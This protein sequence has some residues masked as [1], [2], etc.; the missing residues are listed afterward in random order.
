MGRA[1][2]DGVRMGPLV[3]RA[4]Q[5]RVRD[6]IVRGIA[7]GAELVTGGSEAP[8]GLEGGFFVE[9][10]VFVVDDPKSP[11][12]QEEIFGP[13]AT[14]VPY[15]TVDD[16]VR[17]ANDTP[18]GLGG[19]VRAASDDEAMAVARRIRTGQITINGG[20]FN[21]LAPFGGFKQSATAAK[22]GDSDCRSSSSTSRCSCAKRLDRWPVPPNWQQC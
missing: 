22:A 14:L 1:Q 21:P 11:L 16:A 13:V 3:S 10:T 2:D 20:A 8:A 18:Y 6:C 15:D 9:P 17:I 19:A 5:E 7:T 12:A 4:Q